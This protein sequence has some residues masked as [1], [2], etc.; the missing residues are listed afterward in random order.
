VY[1]AEISN[2]SEQTQN[3]YRVSRKINSELKSI[4][5]QN[6]NVMHFFNTWVLIQR[7]QFPAL[8]LFPNWNKST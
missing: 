5:A 2:N 1:K 8:L 4:L 6:N 3:V 7:K